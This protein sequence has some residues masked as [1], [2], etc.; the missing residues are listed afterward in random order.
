MAKRTT[1]NTTTTTT[2]EAGAVAVATPVAAAPGPRTVLATAKAAAVV[3]AGV[4]KRGNHQ[5]TPNQV[6]TLAA[7]KAAG[8]VDVSAAVPHS[9]IAALTGRAKGN[10]LRQLT[11]AGLVAQYAVP[12]TLGYRFC[13]T[14]N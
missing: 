4:A 6:A 3:A 12:G 2:T 9:A 1:K 13:L 8:A 14:G 5:L 11:A 10:Q 7:L